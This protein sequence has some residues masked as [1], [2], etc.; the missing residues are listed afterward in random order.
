MTSIEGS[1]LSSE[2]GAL[3]VHYRGC[4]WSCLVG[5][6]E[7]GG[8]VFRDSGLHMLDVTDTITHNIQQHIQQNIQHKTT[9]HHIPHIILHLA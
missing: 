4:V 8:M 5:G 7:F 3:F 9:Q 6:S 1:L 2:S